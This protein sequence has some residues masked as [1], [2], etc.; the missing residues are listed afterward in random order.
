MTVVDNRMSYFS[1][2]KSIII[3]SSCIPSSL[4]WATAIL[5][6]LPRIP[7][8]CL[9]TDSMEVTLL[10]RN[11][12]CQPRASSFSTASLIINSFHLRTIVVTAFLS[13]GGVARTEIFLTQES[14]RFRLRGI[15]VAERE[16]ISILDFNALIFSLSNTPNLCSS[17]MMRSPR[18]LK[19]ILSERILCVATTQSIVPLLSHTRICVAS[20]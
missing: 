7:V 12:T 5:T 8:S 4:P 14:A 17:S 3:S 6:C 11:I 10:W 16:S 2:L 18:F 20:F 15:G 9:Q 19:A 13:G 1:F